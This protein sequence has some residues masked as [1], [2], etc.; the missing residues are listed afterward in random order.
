MAGL[1]QLLQ[2]ETLIIAFLLAII[3]P[4]EPSTCKIA[5]VWDF[6]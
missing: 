1:Q 5:R 4:C 3:D 6:A 2:G